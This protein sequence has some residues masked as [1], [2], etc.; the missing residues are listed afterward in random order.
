MVPG[1]SCLLVKKRGRAGR[2]GYDQVTFFFT[3][4]PADPAAVGEAGFLVVFGGADTD[5]FGDAGFVTSPAGLIC[6]ETAFFFSG[7]FFTPSACFTGAVPGVVLTATGFPFFDP[8]AF[9]FSV[10]SMVQLL[11]RACMV[12]ETQR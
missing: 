1:Q 12:R 4:F 8:G 3:V 10:F 9:G 5:F 6:V 11:I 7:R 2:K